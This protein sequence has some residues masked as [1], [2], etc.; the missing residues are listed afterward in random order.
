MSVAIPSI[1][2]IRD[3]HD[4]GSVPGADNNGYA[5]TWNNDAGDNGEIVLVA[6]QQRYMVD[7]RDYGAVPD[8]AQ[9]SDNATI[10]ATAIQ[11]ALDAVKAVGG[12]VVM[13]SGGEFYIGANTLKYQNSQGLILRGNAA[14]TG[15]KIV[16]NGASIV[17]DL[18]GSERCAVENLI[19]NTSGT[20]GVGVLLARATPANVSNG[21]MFQGVYVIGDFSIAAIVNINSESNIFFS[22]HVR[23]TS[24][25]ATAT[26]YYISSDNDAGIMSD[27][28]TVAVAADGATN[29]VIT[30]FGGSATNYGAGSAV[31]VRGNT[32]VLNISSSYL[33]SAYRTVYILHSTASTQ[34]GGVVNIENCSFEGESTSK[35]LYIGDCLLYGLNVINNTFAVWTA[36]DY[37]EI[38]QATQ[39]SGNGIAN[40][41]IRGNRHSAVNPIWLERITNSVV[42]SNG[43]PVYLN[44]YAA[45]VVWTTNILNYSAAAQD[46]ASIRLGRYGTEQRLRLGPAQTT[47]S[48]E[49]GAYST[50][51]IKPS[52]STKTLSTADAGVFE[53]W[54]GQYS[55]Q[56]NGSVTNPQSSGYRPSLFYWSGNE[57]MTIALPRREIMATAAPV[58]LTLWKIA[59]VVWDKAPTTHV[60]WICTRSGYAAPARANST[61]YVLNATVVA[62]PDNGY[63]F[64]CTTAGTS[65]AAP[66]SWSL[67]AGQTTSDGTVVWTR[68]TASVLFARFG[69]VV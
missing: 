13:L 20:C 28:G 50:L 65:G 40:S 10:N 47:A 57:R 38:F 43:S 24:V 34:I 61:A 64:L 58:D 6:A 59:D 55:S 15:T 49:S 9:T 14:Y 51:Q 69:A 45:N 63:Y 46:F 44:T 53:A 26:G 29:S 5:L 48:S 8:A 22:C 42:D 17:F 11:A 66:P 23:N 32:R 37:S 4:F 52:T 1:V 19:I 25:L 36:P 62:D 67:G 27:G 54:N 35:A 31:Y 7:V 12:G 3:A 21:H 56:P 33:Y 60:G 2:R 30:I 41:A 39:S 16:G 18:I 68:Q